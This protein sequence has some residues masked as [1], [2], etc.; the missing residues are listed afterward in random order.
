MLS[1]DIILIII[2][3]I[4]VVL[5]ALIAVDAYAFMRKRKRRD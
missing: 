3:V 2:G 1:T 5:I 4:G